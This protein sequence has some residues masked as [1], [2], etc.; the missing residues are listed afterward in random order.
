MSA[1]ILKNEKSYV[2]ILLKYLPNFLSISRALSLFIIIKLYLSH[3]YAYGFLIYSL[4]AF[5]DVL[6]GYIARKTSCT[7]RLGSII[8]PLCDKIFCLGLVVFLFSQNKISYWYAFLLLFRSLGQIS[9]FFLAFLTRLNVKVDPSILPKFSSYIIYMIL[10]FS[11][12]SFCV[13]FSITSHIL[14]CLIFCSVF[15][16]LVIITLY[17]FRLWQILK[18]KRLGF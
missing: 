14:S 17:P 18:G 11:F 8:D 3:E 2:S 7:S 6:D 9:F 13:K 15:F 4:A 5:S 10:F 16:E 1:T 12:L